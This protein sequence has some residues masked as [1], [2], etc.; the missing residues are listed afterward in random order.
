MSTHEKAPRPWVGWAVF[1]G[2]TA[3]VLGLGLLY[4]TIQE[5]RNEARPAPPMVA[6]DPMETDN[7]KW[8][9]NWPRQWDSYRRMENDTTHTKYGGAHPRDL[10]EETPENVILFAGY[11]FAKEYR[12]ARG[13]WYSVVDVTETERLTEATP[14]TCWTCKSPDVPRVMA[15]LGAALVE[16]PENKTLQQLA[17]AGAGSFYAEKFTDRKAEI[18]SAIGCLDCHEPDTMALRISRPALVE[19]FERRG[20][21]ITQVSHQE[22]RSLVCA[23]C[24]VEYYFKGEGTYLTFP[25]DE[26]LKVEDMEKYYRKHGFTDWTHAISKAPM[27]KMQHP[28]YEVYTHGIHAFRNVSCADCHMPYKTE[29][30][31]KFTDHHVLSPLL[32]VA[33]SCQVCHRWS[34]EDIIGRVETIQSSVRAGR[35]RAE[36]ALAFAHFDVAACMEAGATDEELKGVR[37][38]LRQAQLRWDY[39]AAN[40][41]MGFHAPQECL[42]ILG[43]SVDIAQEARVEAAKI[44]ARHGYTEAVDYPDFSTKEKAQAINQRYVKNDRPSLLKGKNVASN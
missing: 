37:D 20:Q 2:T 33:N 24:H 32:N 40:N 13:H 42:R 29:G 26:G 43:A 44:L 31:V 34:E 30:G 18:T 28:D 8:G 23:Q 36:R 17:S 22:M 19:A 3:G 27:I 35:D 25:W 16:D 10:L 12:Q 7:A 11:G 41:G 15:V 21:D 9:V 14:G 1:A 38:Q 4:A 39:V 6:L 5:R